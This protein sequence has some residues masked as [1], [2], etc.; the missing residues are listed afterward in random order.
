MLCGEVPSFLPSFIHSFIIVLSTMLS[1]LRALRGYL[2]SAKRC[3]YFAPLTL[4]PRATQ[5]MVTAKMFATINDD[6]MVTQL[7]SVSWGGWE[8]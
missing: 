1:S 3:D 4:F 2:F 7:K 8:P 5:A 6:D